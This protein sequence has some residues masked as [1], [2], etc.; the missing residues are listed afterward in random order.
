MHNICAQ[1]VDNMCMQRSTNWVLPYTGHALPV[2]VPRL[3]WVK[4]CFWAL[5]THQ[6]SPSFSTTTMAKSTLIEHYLYPVSTVPIIRT[7]NL[8]N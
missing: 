5:V 7:T 8:N 2:P 4:A 1:Y 3:T 6:L